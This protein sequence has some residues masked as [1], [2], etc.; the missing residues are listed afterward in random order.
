MKK[1][2]MPVLEELDVKMT[3][4]GHKRSNEEKKNRYN[5]VPCPS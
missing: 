5:A 2:E 1:W 4:N 3:A